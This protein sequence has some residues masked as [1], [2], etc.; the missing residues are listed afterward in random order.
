MLKFAANISMLFT[1]I[2]FLERFRAAK[3]AGFR[4]IEFLLPYEH[5]AEDLAA[6]LASNG[7]TQCLFNLPSG[8]WAGGERGIAALPDRVAEFREGIPKAIAYAK[9]M[10]VPSVN[11]LA[12]KASASFSFEDHWKTLVQNIAFAADAFAEHGLTL[13]V[14]HI[15]NKDIGGFYLYNT[16]L[17][18][19]AI[20]E[21]NRPN[22]LLQYD[23]YHA[24]RT[25]G[26]L[27]NIL[28][29]NFDKIGHVQIA[30]NPK[31]NQ[32]GTGEINYPFIFKEMVNLGYKGYIGLEYVP[33][34]DTL[35]SLGWVKEYGYTL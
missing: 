1:E 5:K 33:A 35:G 19:K 28:R 15:N 27:V 14:E 24:Q 11:C 20:A 3:D 31:R 26:E 18:L 4:Y 34:P 21:A 22:V 23:I 7:L 12:G 29:N 9:L 10:K 30:D 6:L 2:P 17:A 16:D 8:N 13:V 32:P 25:E